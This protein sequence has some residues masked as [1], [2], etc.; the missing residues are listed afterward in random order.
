[1]NEKQD[2]NKKPFLANSGNGENDWTL[3]DADF[4]DLVRFRLRIP[5]SA[6]IN[7][8][9]IIIQTK[10]GGIQSVVAP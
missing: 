6:G 7:K 9:Y 8:N 5:K 10:S 4:Q 3:Y 1:M 2:K